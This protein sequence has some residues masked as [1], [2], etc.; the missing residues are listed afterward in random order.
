MQSN[1]FFVLHFYFPCHG[2]QNF[3][4]KFKTQK[5]CQ[6]K[7]RE[8]Q[9]NNFRIKFALF[10]EI[11]IGSLSNSVS[12]LEGSN[13]RSCEE[14][15]GYAD[16]RKGRSL[17]HTN[18]IYNENAHQKQQKYNLLV[19]IIFCF[20]ISVVCNFNLCTLYEGTWNGSEWVP[21]DDY[22]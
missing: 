16:L 9:K 18:Y 12:I 20:H 1:L 21:L 4:G 15:T 3:K 13:M 10:D 7:I 2:K 8:Q 17:F 6:N 5:R 14:I 19:V 22:R 11:F